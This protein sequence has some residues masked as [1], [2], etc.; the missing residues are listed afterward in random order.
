MGAEAGGNLFGPL[1]S[2]VAGGIGVVC[3]YVPLSG[4]RNTSKT[5]QNKK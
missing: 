5:K 1:K 2:T 4:R 3:R